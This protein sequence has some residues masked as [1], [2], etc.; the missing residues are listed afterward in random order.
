M[1]VNTEFFHEYWAKNDSEA[2]N[3]IKEDDASTYPGKN[4]TDHWQKLHIFHYGTNTASTL[5]TVIGYNINIYD[6]QMEC[7]N[8]TAKFDRQGFNSFNYF[9]EIKHVQNREKELFLSSSSTKF[10]TG[11]FFRVKA[12]NY[13]MFS[14]RFDDDSESTIG[15]YPTPVE[16][17]D[18]FNGTG[19][20][21]GLPHLISTVRDHIT[22]SFST[23]ECRQLQMIHPIHMPSVT[24]VTFMANWYYDF[25][26]NYWRFT[27]GGF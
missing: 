16:C 2:W 19:S 20:E 5:L 17:F 26:D 4:I 1:C 10:R 7:P 22:Y 21:K 3:S 23:H 14:S 15:I 8:R 6:K 25:K 18:L 9:G 11:G 13:S 27:Y 24:H 12:G